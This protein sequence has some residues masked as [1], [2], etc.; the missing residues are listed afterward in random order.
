MRLLHLP[1]LLS[2]AL[3][4]ALTGCKKDTA[5]STE[6]TGYAA[7]YARLE[8]SF[9]N[10]QDLADRAV[11][12]GSA[13]NL[14]TT[15]LC[16]TVTH[17]TMS[18]PRVLTI[19]FGSTNCLC[20][21]GKY[22][23]GKIKVAYTG[24]YA[25]S[26][27]VRTFSFDQYFINDNQLTGRK[28]VTNMGRNGQGQPV[29]SIVQN[30]SLILTNGNGIRSWNSTRTRTWTAGYNTT[31][32]TDDAYDVSGSAMLTR[33]SGKTFSILITTP[34]H[35]ALSCD[36]IESGVV[37]ITPT[38]GVTRTLDFGNGGCDSTATLTVNGQTRTVQLP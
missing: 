17:D 33:A 14:K 11:Q 27:T 30:D 21:D 1:L 9:G 13:A 19:D 18:S 32:W 24:R 4:T 20:N 35:R 6:D 29:F 34:L 28:T 15:S 12:S 26:G 23:R 5:S 37:T 36:W 7:D 2:A 10:A 38:G 31:T 22:R 16:A 3:L 25:D 8:N